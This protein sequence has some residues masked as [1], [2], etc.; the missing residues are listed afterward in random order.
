MLGR[1]RKQQSV[2]TAAFR[3]RLVPPR[4][5]VTISAHLGKDDVK[6]ALSR[7]EAIRGGRHP[8]ILK[9]PLEEFS[10]S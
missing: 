2:S 10:P 6:K 7:V 3:S 5:R 1:D 8:E 9:R 4:S